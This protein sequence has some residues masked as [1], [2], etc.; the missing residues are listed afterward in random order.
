[1]RYSVCLEIVG[2]GLQE[3]R[4]LPGQLGIYAQLGQL[5]NPPLS[6]KYLDSDSELTSLLVV[7]TCVK[8]CCHGLPSRG[9]RVSLSTMRSLVIIALIYPYFSSSTSACAFQSIFFKAAF[10]SVLPDAPRLP[11]LHTFP[12]ASA[13]SHLDLNPSHY[14]WRSPSSSL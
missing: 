8:A 7:G 1:M 9:G 12:L 3:E 4:L 6:K 13:P 10:E 5:G 14:Y 11:L 2:S